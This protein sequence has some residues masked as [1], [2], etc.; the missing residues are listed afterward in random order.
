MLPKQLTR[1]QNIADT[2]R[3]LA[4]DVEEK[5]QGV[6]NLICELLEACAIA[7]K[8]SADKDEKTKFAIEVL[9]F[10]STTMNECHFV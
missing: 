4:N 8:E 5:F 6:I 10:L 1:I 9:I 3:D 2:C 7:Q